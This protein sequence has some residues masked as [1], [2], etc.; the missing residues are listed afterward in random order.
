[1]TLVVCEVDV[2]AIVVGRGVAAHAH[3]RDD[4]AR[5]AEVGLD[6]LAPC[7]A[8]LGVVDLLAVDHR[9]RVSSAL[10]ERQRAQ[11]VERRDESKG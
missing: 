10:R 5:R 9:E 11:A 3:L 1:M 7:D 2:Y 6:D 8:H 4:G